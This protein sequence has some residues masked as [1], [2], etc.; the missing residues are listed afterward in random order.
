[1]GLRVTLDT[2]LLQNLPR[3]WDGAKYKSKR[4]A[5]I[6]GLFTI[7]VTDL[8]FWG[9]GFD[10]IDSV[11]ELDYCQTIEVLVESDD[12]QEGTWVTEFNGIIK[13]TEITKIE[14]DERTCTTKI[15]DESFGARINNNKSLKAYVDVGTS[16]NG[17]SITPVAAK[18]I[19]VYDPTSNFNTYE[20]TTREMYRVWN[21]FYFIIQYMTDGDVD[22]YSDFFDVGGDG[23]STWLVNGEE[24]RKGAG[25]G[26]Q[27][28]VSFKNLFKE[29]DK[30]YNLSFAIEPNPTGYSTPYRV[31]VEPTSY[32][33]EEEGDLTLSNIR[34]MKMD[35]NKEA[36]FSDVNIGSD[37][38]DDDVDRSYPPISFKAYKEENYTILGQCNVDKTLDLVSEWIIDTN[39]IE[40]IVVNNEPKYDDKV[41][42]I[43]GNGNNQAYKSKP[44]NE[45]VSI[46][47]TDATTTNKLVDSTANFVGDGVAPGDMLENLDTGVFTYV[48]NVDSATQLTVGDD[49]FPS[50]TNYTVK[51]QPYA[52]NEP[53][54]NYNVISR[55]LGGLPNSV[56][57]YL[58]TSSTANFWAR[59]TAPVTK[60]SFPA[61][62]S[63]VAYDD[64]SISPFFDSGG[65]YSTG[66]YYYTVPNSGLYGFLAKALFRLNGSND[67]T[68]LVT[69]GDFS[70]SN[71][72][73]WKWNYGVISGG[74]FIF[75]ISYYNLAV[76]YLRQINVF[77]NGRAF[78]LSFDLVITSG[79]VVVNNQTFTTSGTHQVSFDFTNTITG[80]QLEFK[81]AS[82]IPFGN[83]NGTLDNVTVYSAPQFEITQTIQR[84]S[85]ANT[86]LQSFSNTYQANFLP[87]QVQLDYIIE[88]QKTFSTFKNERINVIIEIEANYGTNMSFQLK[89]QQQGELISD[90]DY[91]SFKTLSV[92]DGGGDILPVDPAEFPI[93]KYE[94][95]KALKFE[96]WNS[97]KND[98]KSAVLFSNKDSNHLYGWR[99]SIEYDRKTGETDFVLRSKEKINTDC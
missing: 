86:L 33:E 46:G 77:Q 31:R 56:V 78:V 82:T 85:S 35:F 43:I 13:L 4:D 44:Y 29:M 7:Y 15:F 17:V 93:Y 49:I 8:V 2:T 10:Y 94:F 30:K 75:N 59:I 63:Y 23:Y 11:M 51:T 95:K 99:N 76:S 9:D 21:C 73:D 6:K 87:N 74:K 42:I 24:L 38:F 27:L 19:S 16:K 26:R 58:S 91:T 61:T 48:S 25:N 54:N 80:G 1:M 66:S 20:V 69:N 90:I 36:L 81:F 70:V 60:T 3:G 62:I 12:C 47:I 89:E 84:R 52:Y 57:K 72:V 79:A 64:D 65:N 92:D 37:N 5:D 71:N 68:N 88:T 53:I 98:P 83:V 41:V 28:E 40:D 96:E 34:G 97:L 55:Y 45:P 22:F 14:L 39:I 67:T 32:F 18:N 50:G